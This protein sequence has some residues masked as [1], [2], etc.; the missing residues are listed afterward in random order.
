[1]PTN[2]NGQEEKW[3]FKDFVEYSER[4]IAD[5]IIRGGFSSIRS[6]MYN[7]VNVYDACKKEGWKKSE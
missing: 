7:I 1:M 3:D 5:G 4:L 2:H 6:S